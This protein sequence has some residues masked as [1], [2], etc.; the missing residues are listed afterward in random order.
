MIE[1]ISLRCAHPKD[2]RDFYAKALAPIGYIQD[3]VMGDSYAFKH[4]GHHDLWI[5]R[6]VVGTP[7]HVAFNC[8]RR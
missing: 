4:K 3:W 1:H 6:G 8:D 5:T 7:L 2:S